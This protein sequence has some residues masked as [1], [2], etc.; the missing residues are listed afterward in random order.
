[1]SHPCMPC[2]TKP[3]QTPSSPRQGPRGALLLLAAAA[4]EPPQPPQPLSTHTPPHPP[5][6]REPLPPLRRGDGAPAARTSCCGPGEA[7]GRPLQPRRLRDRVRHQP[8][9]ALWPG[10]RQPALLSSPGEGAHLIA[11]TGRHRS[12]VSRSN[13]FACLPCGHF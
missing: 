2:Q 9:G 7:G 5:E 1:M 11:A 3:H 13:M 6:V 8:G 12:V 10:H 4:C